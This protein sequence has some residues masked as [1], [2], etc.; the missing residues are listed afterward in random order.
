MNIND[1]LHRL[2]NPSQDPEE[3]RDTMAHAARLIL[4]MQD[5]INYLCDMKDDLQDK[6]DRLS[7][8]LGLKDQGYIK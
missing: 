4:L 6:V 3:I 7:L 8:D 2:A 1:L 5:R